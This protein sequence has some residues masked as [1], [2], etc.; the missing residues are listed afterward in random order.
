MRAV[1]L[2]KI[3]AAARQFKRKEEGD[4]AQTAARSRERSLRVSCRANSAQRCRCELRMT[5]ETVV[6]RAREIPTGSGH[7]CAA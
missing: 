2:P 6:S 7:A 1:T 5:G 4:A 3:P